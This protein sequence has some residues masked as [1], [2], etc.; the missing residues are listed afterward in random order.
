MKRTLKRSLAI[1]AISAAAAWAGALTLEIGKPDADPEA[2]SM[3]A[4]LIARVTACSSPE[5][6][7]LTAS[8]VQQNGSELR[9]TPLKV[10]AMKTPG[11]YAI[12]GATPAG[13]VIDLAV[14][15]PD[16]DKSYQPRV[17]LRSDAHGVQWASVKRFY[18]V[19]PTDSDVKSILG[20][21]D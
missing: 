10:V 15:N 14:T 17:L 8:L 3:N 12:I 7:R 2:K 11:S 13:S 9:R 18:S 6:S 21:M 20:A 19:P 16:Y 1:A 5:K 4:A